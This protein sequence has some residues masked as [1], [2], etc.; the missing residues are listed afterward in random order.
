[1]SE[2]KD[3]DQG[4]GRL[5]LR[6]ATRADVGRTVDGGS[7][8]QSFSHGRSKVV[9]VEV[10][11]KRGPTP[12]PGAGPGGTPQRAGSA[13]GR[14]P[15]AGRALTAA[16]LATRQ[17]VLEA[18][19]QEAARRDAERREQEKISVLSAAEEARRREDEARR[20]AE[21]AARQEQAEQARARAE[22]E[23]ARRAAADAEAA[24]AEA[25]ETEAAE[26]EAAEAAREVSGEPEAPVP[27]ASAGTAPAAAVAT[28]PARPAV[29]VSHSLGTGGITILSNENQP[30]RSIASRAVGH[31][32]VVNTRPGGGSTAAPAETLRLRPATTRP[33]T[34]T[35]EDDRGRGTLRRPGGA[36]LPARRPGAMPV[37]KAGDRR[38][39]GR[40]D[41][42]AAIAGDDDKTRS[43]A[44]V[45]RQRDRER[46]QA[47]L[48]QLRS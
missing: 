46:R 42:Q 27:A 43:L 20:D 33:G 35:E 44:S 5:S 36:A 39:S 34:G 40:V 9:Q 23:E 8:R 17:R 18:Q 30:V 24:A 11:K 21:E 16:E 41:V 10:R 29:T 38:N 1:M 4:K 19:Q 15:G 7:V 37:R 48:E 2:G 28:G 14:T 22:A 25:A 45:R 6:P 31:A 12:T 13:P 47:E 3:Q 32:P 26:A